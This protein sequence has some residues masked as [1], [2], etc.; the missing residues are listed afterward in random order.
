MKLCKQIYKLIQNKTLKYGDKAVNKVYN[1][2]NKS[3]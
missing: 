1:S 3:W 2:L